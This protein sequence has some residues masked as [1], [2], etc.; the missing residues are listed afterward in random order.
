MLDASPWVPTAA[1]IRRA[2][3]GEAIEVRNRC[4]DCSYQGACVTYL[5]PRLVGDRPGANIVVT[6]TAYSGACDG[7]CDTLCHDIRHTCAIPT[8]PPGA[9]AYDIVVDGEV[10]ATLGRGGFETT[11]CED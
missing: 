11:F 5:E 3:G 9:G 7:V 8:L 6:P 4:G 1:C 10:L 2:G